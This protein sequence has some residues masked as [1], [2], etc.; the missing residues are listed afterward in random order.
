MLGDD[1]PNVG[2]VREELGGTLAR[3][4]QLVEAEALPPRARRL[5]EQAAADHP[6][7]ADGSVTLGARARFG[8][9]RGEAEAPL[10]GALDARRGASAPPIGAQAEARLE[11]GECLRA[12]ATPPRRHGSWL[13][14]TR[15]SRLARRAAPLTRRAA[16][17]MTSG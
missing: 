2:S 14:R 3:A 5:P 16:A 17:L 1:H 15:R 12:M 6:W 7:I 9:S 10:R 11:L 13:R 8:W 4:G